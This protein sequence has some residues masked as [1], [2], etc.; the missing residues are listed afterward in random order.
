MIYFNAFPNSESELVTVYL[1]QSC[2]AKKKVFDFDFG[3]LAIKGRSSQGNVLTKYPVRKISQKSVGSSTLGGRK[4]WIDETVGR[5]NVDERGR[6]LGEF[7]GEDQIL[8]IYKD[9]SYKLTDFE[10]TNRYEM[11][12][13]ALV[14]KLTDETVVTALHYEGKNKTYFVKRF[15]IETS[16][17]DKTFLFISDTP[18]SKLVHVSV[19]NK[20]FVEY[21]VL[22]KNKA[23]DTVHLDLADFIEV[24]GWRALGNR[25]DRRKVSA[26]KAIENPNPSVEEELTTTNGNVEGLKTGDQVEWSGEDLNNGQ[27]NLFK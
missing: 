18:G 2:R 16:T 3:E 20:V 5:L 22:L 12:K 8:V 21:K 26:I 14:K 27:G 19:D 10:L 13:V 24:K 15:Q 7:D 4:I 23:K 17:K 11:N 9:G 25:L 1:S 6:F